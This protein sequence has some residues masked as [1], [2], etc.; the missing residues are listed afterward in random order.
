LIEL[1]IM[2]VFLACL[3]FT[4]LY[5]LTIEI[6]FGVITFGLWFA[7][8]LIWILISP[9]STSYAFGFLFQGVGIL[10]LVTVIYQYL[11][12]LDLQKGYEEEES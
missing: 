2:I 4:L 6:L 12:H 10:F 5:I 7:F 1:E 11:R 3:F 8:G 9:M